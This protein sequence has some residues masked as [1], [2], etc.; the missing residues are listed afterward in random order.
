K[1]MPG[2]EVRSTGDLTVG[3]AWDF[4]SGGW[5]SA[6]GPGFLT[7]R[8]TGDLSIDT[9]CNLVDHPTNMVSLNSGNAKQTWGMTLVS[10][11]N[12]AGA[13]PT[14]IAAQTGAFE[15]GVKD[16]TIAN[17][18]VVY[19][20]DAPL[21]LAAGVD[22]IIGSGAAL[23]YMINA[24]SYSAATYS[25]AISA[26]AGHDVTINGGAIESAT[27]S[28]AVNAGHDLNLNLLNGYLGSIRTTGEVTGPDQII[29]DYWHYGNGG[30]IEIR[31]KGSVNGADLLN[32]TSIWAEG[33]DSFNIKNNIEYGWSADYG[34][35]SSDIVT[36]GL[37]T[38]AGG[39]LTVYAGGDFT[40]QAGTFSPYAYTTS[41]G[42]VLTSKAMN[43][44]GNL[45]IFSG[46]NMEGRF[47]IA[48]G[49]G[50]L[51]AM[52]NFG[53]SGANA[54]HPPIELFNATLNVTARGDIN[55][56]VV[57]NPTI[58]RPAV[59]AINWDLEYSPE[60][61]AS[62]TSVTGNVSLYG[63]DAYYG[64]FNLQDYDLLILPPTVAVRAAGN[65]NILSDFALAPYRHGELILEAGKNIDGLKPN[66]NRAEIHM[67]EQS[68]EP[69][70]SL[71]N[72][73]YGPQGI[74]GTGPDIGNRILNSLGYDDP[75][76]IL[77]TGDRTPIIISAGGDISNLAL[78]VPKET[79]ITAGADIS[80]IYYFGHNNGSSDVTAIRAGGNIVFS[81]VPNYDV[82][83]AR[84]FTGIQVGGP[85]TLVVEAG[86][87]MDLGTTAGIQAVGNVWDPL[88]LPDA[89][90]TLIV[91]AG[92]SKDFSNVSADVRFF[93][94]IQTEGTNYSIDLAAGD[95]AQ[96][97]QIVA[98]ARADVI[99]PFFGKSAA[100]G[101]GDIDMTL[102]QVSSLCGVAPVFV[103]VNGSLNVGQST[104]ITDTQRQSTG[105][106]T[107]QGGAINIFAV[108]DVNVNESRVMTFMG[109]D[110]IVWSDTGSINAGIGSKTA[111]VASPPALENVNGEEVLVFSP[112]S[113]GSGIRAVTYNPDPEVDAE[114]PL[115]G[116]IYLFAPQGDINAGEAG[117]AGRNVILGAVQVLNA[118]NIVFSQGE[119]GVPTA[120][121]G[122]S[123]LSVLSGTG[124]VTQQMQMAQAASMSAAAN[125]P[126]SLFSLPEDS[127]TAPWIEVRALSVFDV[128][129]DDGSWEKTDN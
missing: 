50:E 10:G 79:Q 51:H 80:D 21:Y 112:P 97:Q 71:Y 77:H 63:D 69:W 11:T 9:G 85:G 24:I 109:G 124:S 43:D 128:E 36:E 2:L 14:A 4:T 33:W 102:S 31:V 93:N 13:N 118:N 67:S 58:A 111:I 46:G 38:M 122:F 22:L 42:T 23:G 3:N 52:G 98:E 100:A 127:F 74:G 35:G 104:F 123:G 106:F 5:D 37:A 26:T 45:T 61:S 29:R 49:I 15:S 27:G 87:S 44:R 62:F 95:T 30:N 91:A 64:V 41:H 78:F 20:E 19:T 101:S 32:Q 94:S 113:V 84:D 119:I 105:I 83:G 110:I 75:Y 86:G 18:A 59:N 107:A 81:S 121:T 57:V 12:L 47:L 65:I 92:Y 103:F 39:N 60:T 66:G 125:K 90:A 8:A 48:D 82:Q 72:Q 73:V 1:L 16:L 108:G 89:G 17:K 40:C 25:G 76:G 96:A 120:S 88:Q 56:G 55:I 126:A 70:G 6:V 129:P 53:V 68:D 28:I 7:L 54:N 99:A 114:P 34:S 116:N 117:I 115:A